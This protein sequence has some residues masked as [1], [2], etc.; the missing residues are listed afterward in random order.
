MDAPSIVKWIDWGR[1][2]G[3]RSDE[4]EPSLF[5]RVPYAERVFLCSMEMGWPFGAYPEWLG[6]FWHR[7]WPPPIRRAQ[8]LPHGS[9]DFAGWFAMEEK[10]A[11]VFLN[12]LSAII[13]NGRDNLPETLELP[14]FEPAG[15]GFGDD[16]VDL[17]SPTS[18]YR[19]ALYRD[20]LAL[21]GS[22]PPRRTVGHR[23][24]LPGEGL[25]VD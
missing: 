11:E 3:E 21:L 16:A 24:W 13:R 5:V 23:M 6:E 25:R 8:T 7:R 1:G 22:P 15:F 2:G 19:Y 9:D 18:K 17:R 4:T 12:A 20:G 14:R 10:A